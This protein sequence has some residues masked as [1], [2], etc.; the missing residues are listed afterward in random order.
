MRVGRST[1]AALL[2]MALLLVVWWFTSGQDGETSSRDAQ[3]S[4]S[5]RSTAPSA[6]PS[7]APSKEVPDWALGS[8]TPSRTSSPTPPPSSTPSR[9]VTARPSA[10]PSS[11]ARTDEDGFRWVAAAELPHPAQDVLEA[12][13]AGGPFAHAGKDGSTFGN[14]EQ[15]LPQRKRGY[16]REYTVDTPGLNHRGARRIVTGQG[17]QFYW[18]A[19]HYESFARIRR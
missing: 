3:S 8:D 19:D 11:P 5:E 9:T 2:V 4:V 18:T 7:T 16:Y 1:W 12:I 17:G 13:D 10:R 14:Y 6:V 15:V